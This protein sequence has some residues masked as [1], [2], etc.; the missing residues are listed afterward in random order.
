LSLKKRVDLHSH[1]TASDGLFSPRDLV[2]RAVRLGLSALALTDHDNTDGLDEALQ[3]G[4]EAGLEVVAGVEISADYEPGTMHLVGLGIDPAHAGLQTK[5]RFLQEAR[6][7]RN[8]RIVKLLQGAGLDVTWQ[9]V[10]AQAKGGQVG[11]PHFAMVLLEKKI[12]SSWQEAFDLWLGKGKPGYLPK[13]RMPAEEA[14]EVIHAAGG[15]AVLAH[16]I[17]L[18]LEG[19]PLTELVGRLKASGLDAIEVFHSDHGPKEEQFYQNLALK[20]GLRQSGGSDFHGHP[21]KDVELGRPEVDYAL[22]EGL[23]AK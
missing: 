5:L 17:Q 19:G 23:R 13:E 3:A 12:V 8:P 9:E 7:T 11:R 15:K 20:N 1:S 6:A 21:D 14:I 2:A 18:K 16:P 10:L 22:L 4:R